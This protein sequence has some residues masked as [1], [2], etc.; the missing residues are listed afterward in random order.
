MIRKAGALLT[1]AGVMASTLA[2][3]GPRCHVPL[4]DWQPREALREKVRSL[5]WTLIRIKTDDGCY[6]IYGTDEKGQRIKAKF[7]PAT[8]DILKRDDDD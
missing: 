1:L 3:A 8:L 4:A 7:N 2:S 6:K 5:G